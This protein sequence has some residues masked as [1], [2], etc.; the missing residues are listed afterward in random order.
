M[1]DK[2]VTSIPFPAELQNV[3]W[4][5]LVGDLHEPTVEITA[6]MMK[7]QQIVQ[8]SENSYARICSGSDLLGKDFTVREDWQLAED[9]RWAGTLEFYGNSSK[10]YVE[11]VHFPCITMPFPQDEVRLLVGVSQGWTYTFKRDHEDGTLIN[12]AFGSLRLTSAFANGRGVY[13]DCRDEKNNLHNYLWSKKDGNLEYHSI[14]FLP[15]APRYRKSNKLGFE[16]SIVTFDGDWFEAAQIYRKWALTTRNYRNRIRNNRQRDLAIWLWNRGGSEH[17]IQP[18]EKLARD[19]GVLVA[20]DWYWWHNNPYDTN[21]PNFW[22]PR[23]GEEVFAAAQKRL[24]EQGIYCQVY[25]NGLT[26]DV[27]L[28]GF[29]EEGGLDSAVVNRDGSVFSY[30]FNCYT[31]HRLGYMCGEGDIFKKR[32]MQLIDHLVEAGLPGVYLDM[33]GCA[34]LHPCYNRKHHHAPGGGNYQAR[35]YRKMI[36]DIRKKYPELQLSTESCN[37]IFMDCFE[38]GIIL[39]SSMERCCNQ[40]WIDCFPVFAAV[41]HGANTLFGNYALLDGVPPWDPLWPPRDRWKNEE[42]W[43]AVCPDQFALE[44]ARTVIWGMQPTVCNLTM[45]QIN[46]PRYAEDYQWIVYIARFY[47]E[48]RRYLYDG[49]MLDPSGFDCKNIPVKFLQRGLFTTEDKKNIMVRERPAVLHSLWQAP[50]GSKALIVINYTRENQS[51]SYN[52]ST[53]E[54]PPRTARVIE[55][56]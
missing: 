2:S 25:I 40:E 10:L 8:T 47:Y 55:L 35:G 21:Y 27:D 1:K 13:V 39:S 17:V 11:E 26:W 42:D 29:E 38:S 45:E 23:E 18:A 7:K 36:K 53:Y 24:K 33:I 43:H 20:L 54:L 3:S 34:A 49:V 41:Y 30:E 5:L 4:S 22:P 15:C 44:L 48:N 50:D 14:H 9:N 28:E 6:A 51:C 32:I 46:D 56:V 37:E 19:C 52:N 31:H 12:G 16:N